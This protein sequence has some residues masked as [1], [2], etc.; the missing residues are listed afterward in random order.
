MT[1]DCVEGL[2]GGSDRRVDVLSAP[3]G[4]FGQDLAGRGVYDAGRNGLSLV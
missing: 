2:L 4:D 3:L 1:P